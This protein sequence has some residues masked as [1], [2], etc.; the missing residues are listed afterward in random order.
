MM[1]SILPT[2]SHTQSRAST[3]WPATGGKGEKYFLKI[4]VFDF[5]EILPKLVYLKKSKTFRTT[6]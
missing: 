2:T 1:I 3:N 6:R 5:L 4:T